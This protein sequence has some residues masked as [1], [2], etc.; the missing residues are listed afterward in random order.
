MYEWMS[1]GLS[2]FAPGEPLIPTTKLS[3]Y[4]FPDDGDQRTLS[5]S[6]SGL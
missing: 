5:Y 6:A 1:I 3:I 2:K 4:V